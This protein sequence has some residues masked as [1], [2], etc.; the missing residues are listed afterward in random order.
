MPRTRTTKKLAQR[1]DMNYFKRP[2]ALRRWRFLLSVAML[3][4]AILWLA[5]Y[6]V[7]RDRQLYSAGNLSSAHAVLTKQC[8]ACHVSQVWYFSEKASDQKCLVCHDGPVHHGT[9][10][11]TPS[12]SSCHVDHRGPVRLAET[13]DAACTQCHANLATRG[14]PV[15][16]VRNISAFNQNHPE[17]AAVRGRDGGTI[18]MNHYLHLQPNLLGPN[19]RVQMTCM[20]CH[21]SDADT[22][23]P[24]RFG[25]S[26][27]R[28]GASPPVT[29]DTR[30]PD[31]F[32]PAPS[33]AY[34]A[35]PAYVR[36]CANCHSL[37]FDKR[38][39]ESV[40]HSTPEEI[41]KFIVAKLQAYIAAHP[42]EVRVPRDPS[43]V[44]P[45]KP[46]TAEFRVLTPGQ[47]VTER[48]SDAEQL[49]WRKTCRQCHTLTFSNDNENPG[50][51]KIEPSNITVRF[52][53]HAKFDH[54]KHGL[55]ACTACHAGATTSQQNSDLLLPGIATCQKC[56]HEGTAAAESRC[57]E[58]H[59]YH[60]PAHHQPAHSNFSLPDLLASKFPAGIA[61]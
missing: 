3:A 10:T 59:T 12:C 7:R 8:A 51:P 40:P 22:N 14:S 61:R 30:K 48:T 4:L 6:G 20:D 5:W 57:F 43:R 27:N 52:L 44:L 19:G 38:I 41:H 55:V 31:P 11:F 13:S 39:A 32:A 37:Q 49:L 29:T 56:H 60:D 45:E 50:L 9:Q 23:R 25:D 28:A 15:H 58:C 26:H 36:A 47:W 1:I 2:H 35:A 46:V 17:F 21:R 24:W 16:F 53:P 34:M 42:A 33:R 54:S 18:R